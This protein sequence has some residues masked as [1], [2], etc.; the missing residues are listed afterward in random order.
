MWDQGGP[1]L[2]NS[3]T[4]DA[5]L[6]GRKPFIRAAV[7]FLLIY[8]FVRSVFNAAIHH[9]WF[10]ELCAW[11]VVQQPNLH[12]VW[13]ALM[14]GTDSQPPPFYLVEK[15]GRYVSANDEV[16][17]R[18][19]AALGFCCMVGCIF[20]WLRRR[21]N[22]L[23]AFVA[24]LI[25]LM[26][27]F[28]SRYAAQARG[29]GL[30]GG[31]LSLALLAYQGVPQ[32]KW[33]FVLA[34]SLA[35]AESFH[36]YAFIMMGPLFAAEA[37]F[38]L[39]KKCLR[40]QVWAALCCGVLPLILFWPIVAHMKGYY[41][42]HSWM[43]PEF[44][45]TLRIYGWLLG[46]PQG[47]AG[48]FSW[49]EAAEISLSAICL[50]VAALLV[51]KALR[52]NSKSEPHFHENILASGFLLLPIV[53]F[54]IVKT[55]S[56]TLMAP[57]YLLTVSI[58]IVMIAAMGLGFL[59]R[60]ALK[61][62]GVLLCAA[63]A[64]QEAGFWLSYYGLYQLGFREPQPVQELVLKA[65]HDELPVVVSEGHDYLETEHYAAP[66]WKQ[67]LMFV[68]DYPSALAHGRSDFNDKQLLAL[69]TLA[70]LRVIEY[71]AFKERQSE[72]L[73]YSDPTD[74]NDPDWFVLRLLEDHWSLQK[75]ASDGHSTVYLVGLEGKTRTDF[76]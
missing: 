38:A 64:V 12:S 8:V 23:V 36:Y 31:A 29:Y 6:G 10:D 62:I 54:V 71:P 1:E 57:R 52:A 63:I 4:G 21:H 18:L 27:P 65:G 20:F 24:V 14:R 30:L 66:A 26:T 15:L 7:V 74:A 2:N 25:F 34:I 28:F 3:A 45:K 76:R 22:E 33:I 46:M 32:T 43:R 48:G 9:L 40:W 51:Y 75:L 56:H 67:R 41:T 61:L 44:F 42:E 49:A 47:T 69:R 39:K 17:L 5:T 58:G 13:Q 68:A 16:G 37:L 59:S 19:P 35:A 50:S 60:S 53:L 11:F 73:L 70:P 72:F 55:T